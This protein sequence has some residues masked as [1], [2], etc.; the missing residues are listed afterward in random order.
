MLCVSAGKAKLCFGGEE[1]PK[2]AEIEV[3]VGDVMIVPAGVAHRLLED[4]EGGFEMVG[5]YPRGKQW[6]MCYGK[7]GEEGLVQGIEGI[8]WFQQ[9]PFYGD[10]GPALDV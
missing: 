9:D 1:N 2:R 7:A 6:D 10:K 8:E 4:I 5:C 3:E